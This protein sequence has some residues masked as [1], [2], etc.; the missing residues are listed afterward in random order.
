[1]TLRLMVSSLCSHP[2]RFFVFCFVLQHFYARRNPERLWSH[3]LLDPLPVRL[4]VV[5]ESV[6]GI[7]VLCVCCPEWSSAR[8]FCNSAVLS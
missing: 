4:G 8:L 6:E 5:Q 1:M 7:R 2:Q 3:R